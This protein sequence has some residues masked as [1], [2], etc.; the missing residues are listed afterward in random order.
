MVL[1]IGTKRVI[2]KIIFGPLVKGFDRV[3]ELAVRK[4]GRGAQNKLRPGPLKE[5]KEKKEGSVPYVFLARRA[6]LVV[7][8]PSMVVSLWAKKGA[9]DKLTRKH[10]MLMLLQD[11]NCQS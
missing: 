6:S 1:H 3:K 11:L 5:R 7:R 4:L 10:V 9:G 2:I 8:M